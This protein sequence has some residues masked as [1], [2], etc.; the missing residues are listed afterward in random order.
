MARVRGRRSRL[1][2]DRSSDLAVCGKAQHSVCGD[3]V[4][5]PS[6]DGRRWP[7]SE[8]KGTDEGPVSTELAFPS[9][10]AARHLLPTGEGPPGTS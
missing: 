1:G 8:A 3:T 2:F 6:P 4:L 10:A 9:S 7:Q 5:G